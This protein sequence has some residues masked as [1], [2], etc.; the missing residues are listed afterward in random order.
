MVIRRRRGQ[1]ELLEDLT[2]RG[3]DDPIEILALVLVGKL[4]FGLFE[5]VKRL[6]RAFVLGLVGVDD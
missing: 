3:F 1:L 5:Q 6:G 2:A 4:R